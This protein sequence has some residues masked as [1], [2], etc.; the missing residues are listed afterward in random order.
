MEIEEVAEKVA[1]EVKQAAP[2][3]DVSEEELEE[4]IKQDGANIIEK[5]VKDDVVKNEEEKIDTFKPPC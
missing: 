2:K 4:A 5:E 1:K 3:S